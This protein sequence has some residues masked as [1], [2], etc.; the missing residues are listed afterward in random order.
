MQ[1]KHEMIRAITFFRL[2]LLLLL[3]SVFLILS[4]NNKDKK[5]TTGFKAN[6]VVLKKAEIDAW[7]KDT[8]ITKGDP[9]SIKYVLLQFYSEKPGDMSGNL[10]LVAYPARSMSDVIIKGRTVLALDLNGPSVSIEGPAAFASS[11]VCTETLFAK[12]YGD[13]YL[14]PNQN[15]QP[16]LGYD[17]G[18][19]KADTK[20]IDTTKNPWPCPPYCCP[21]PCC[22]VND[23][24]SL[25]IGN[26]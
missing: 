26:E 25:K 13:V 7:M 20:A 10:Q 22:P 19:M 24:I 3:P 8:S 5:K 6:T 15:N 17:M 4:C 2:L 11:F 21:G 14:Y 18:T 12:G 23:T 9:A 16:Y 1:K